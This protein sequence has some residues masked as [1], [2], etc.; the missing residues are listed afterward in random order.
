MWI[1]YLSYIT[2]F[3]I[4]SG[5]AVL[6]ILISWQLFQEH[7]M[8]ILSTVLYQQVFLYSFFIYGI[9]GNL[10]LQAVI[11]DLNLSETL[12]AK[13]S[14]FIPI[15][16]IP[17]LVVSWFMLLKF[18]YN[19]NGYRLPRFFIY[20]YFPVF[21]GMVFLLTLLLQ[22]EI[23]SIPE[24]P[25][26]FIVRVIA[27]FHLAVHTLFVLPF[28]R[29][30]DKSGDRRK[31]GIGQKT[32]QL[33]LV[34]IAICTVVLYFYQVFG[35]IST[36]IAII[37]LFAGNVFLPVRIWITMKEQTVSVLD[38]MDFDSFCEY[39]EISKREAEIVMEIC[40]GKSNKEISE[41]LFIT[42]QTVKDHNHRIFTKTG[43]RSRVQL[44]NLVR[45]KIR[46]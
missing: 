10:A 37:L 8:Q 42:L 1:E 22:R 38:G 14:F 6:G 27:G 41:K 5:T 3:I 32:A 43:V 20:S 18:A 2:T 12:S 17:F 11:A 40:A 13:L 7:K 29:S 44:A 24:Q 35:F 39:Y 36:C 28:L 45:E 31:T 9:W 34:I 26:L 33:Y 19:I 23:I 15:M 21:V 4:T 25:E 46:Q 30:R 16:G